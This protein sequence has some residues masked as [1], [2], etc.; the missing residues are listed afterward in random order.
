MLFKKFQIIKPENQIKDEQIKAVNFAIVLLKY[1]LKIMIQKCIQ[2]TMKKNLLKNKQTLKNKIY[3]HMTTV[4]KN[5]YID[6]LNDIINEYN[7][8]YQNN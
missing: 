8:T 3:E 6:K 7:N 4:S 2:H 5:V 1:G